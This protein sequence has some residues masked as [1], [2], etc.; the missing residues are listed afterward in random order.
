MPPLAALFWV[1]KYTAPCFEIYPKDFILHSP[2][3]PEEGDITLELFFDF[4]FIVEL[5][6]DTAVKFVM[7]FVSSIQHSDLKLTLLVS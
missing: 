5:P 7:V 2:L 1:K 3:T 4:I 6:R